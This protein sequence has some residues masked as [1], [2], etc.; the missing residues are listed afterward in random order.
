MN[1][2]SL[3]LSILMVLFV[4]LSSGWLVLRNQKAVQENHKPPVVAENPIQNPEDIQP[5]AEIDTSRWKTYRNEEYGFTVKYPEG[6]S[7][8][9][10][11][12]GGGSDPGIAC[13]SL[14]DE[15]HYSVGFYDTNKRSYVA[16]QV[17]PRESPQGEDANVNEKS[18]QFGTTLSGLKYSVEN[19]YDAMLSSCISSAHLTSSKNQDIFSVSTTHD[20]QV[21]KTSD[22]AEKFCAQEY[23]DPTFKGFLKNFNVL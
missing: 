1:Q 12:S 7:M 5:S 10:F 14:S 11:F 17:I 18:N 22:D 6:W 16:V 3:I 4:V 8:E 21:H 19:V 9:V 2:K 13:K 15:C 20:D 23:K